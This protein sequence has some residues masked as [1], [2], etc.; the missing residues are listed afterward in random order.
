M[1][2]SSGKWLGPGSKEGP[3]R[4]GPLQFD[5][6]SSGSNLMPGE[7]VIV[8]AVRDGKLVVVPKDEIPQ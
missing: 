3:V 7:T 5:A 4:I 1:V 6:V 2:G 8:T